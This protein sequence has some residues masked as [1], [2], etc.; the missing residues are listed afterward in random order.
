LATRHISSLHQSV[1]DFE[2]PDCLQGWACALEALGKACLLSERP[3]LAKFYLDR[4]YKVFCEW[5]MPCL[6]RG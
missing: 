2:N 6:L 5:E 4:A 1:A 3:E